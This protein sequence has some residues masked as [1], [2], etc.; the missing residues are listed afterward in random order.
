MPF[1]KVYHTQCDLKTAMGL[2]QK[3]SN[4]HRETLEENVVWNWYNLIAYEILPYIEIL[5]FELKDVWF[6]NVKGYL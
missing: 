1:G 6:R 5:T 3:Y 2:L 4:H